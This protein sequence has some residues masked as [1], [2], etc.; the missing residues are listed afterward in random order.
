MTTIERLARYLAERD[1][2]RWIEKPALHSFSAN[3]QNDYERE[4]ARL[5]VQIDAW[6]LLRDEQPTFD[7]NASRR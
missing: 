7:Q 3:A 5:L 2:H 4:A 6:R 1:R